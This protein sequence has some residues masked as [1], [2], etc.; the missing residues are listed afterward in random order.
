MAPI[1][2]IPDQNNRHL[3]DGHHHNH[4][5]SHDNRDNRDNRDIR[6]NRDDEIDVFDT[7][8]ISSFDGIPISIHDPFALP[9]NFPFESIDFLLGFLSEFLSDIGLLNGDIV[10]ENIKSIPAPST[11]SSSKT[12]VV[13]GQSGNVP[14]V[15]VPA[16]T[17]ATGT[18]GPIIADSSSSVVTGPKDPV[19]P[20]PAVPA[21]TNPF[22]ETPISAA[23]VAPG[24]TVGQP[25]ATG[26][27]A[28]APAAIVP[29]VNASATTDP[30]VSAPPAI[31]PVA[32]LNSK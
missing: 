8:Q 5:H 16:E 10:D 32:E 31:V 3:D 4:R 23:P 29:A 9:S 24:E 11:G 17:I 14:Q 25:G 30:L 18:T 28:I 2:E 7:F 12:P 1:E 26:A 6:V 15:P 20:V 27:A 22:V 13:T 19:A 21:S